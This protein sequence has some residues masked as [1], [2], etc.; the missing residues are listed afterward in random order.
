L[1]LNASYKGLIGLLLITGDLN[2]ESCAMIQ[3]RQVGL[4]FGDLLAIPVMVGQQPGVN[5]PCINLLD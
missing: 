5:Q 2:Y 1:T 3:G 4:D